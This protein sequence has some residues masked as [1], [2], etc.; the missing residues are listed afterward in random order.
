MEEENVPIRN[1]Q[2]AVPGAFANAIV[3]DLLMKFHS[4]YPKVRLDIHE[5][6]YYEI[7]ESMDKGA[8]S[9]GVV[10]CDPEG[11]NNLLKQLKEVDIECEIISG[12]QTRLFVFLSSKN[13]L[14]DR[15]WLSSSDLKSMKMI[16]YKEN[17]I[18]VS[19]ILRHQLNKPIIVEDIELLKKL[20]SDDFGFSIFP[21]ILSFNDLYMSS[22]MIKA[23]PVQELS[24]EFD[25][26][27]LYTPYESLS[28]IE[29]E[30]L[31][32]VKELIQDNMV[33]QKQ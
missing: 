14:S 18:Q 28:Y 9:I 4:L 19:K 3:P 23:I 27:I 30:L 25:I 15:E 1:L 5:T 6:P 10:T 16:S 21:E 11:K 32:L 24:E 33:K 13:L 20:I 29:K 17:Y 22:G 2:M 26:F 31:A 12:G 8:Y 7:V